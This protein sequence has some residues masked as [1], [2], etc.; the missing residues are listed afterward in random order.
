[1]ADDDLNDLMAELAK[2][3]APGDDPSRTAADGANIMRQMETDIP[4]HPFVSLAS[5]AV[6]LTKIS[7]SLIQINQTLHT[8]NLGQGSNLNGIKDATEKMRQELSSINGRIGNVRNDKQQ[9]L[10]RAIMD[11]VNKF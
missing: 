8:G 9:A 10:Q 4:I 6:S 1:M 3:S 5:I 2:S 11:V 7:T